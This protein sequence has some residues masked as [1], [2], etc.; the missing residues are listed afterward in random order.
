MITVGSRKKFINK[1]KHWLKAW[2]YTSDSCCSG[3][4]AADQKAPTVCMSKFPQQ[5][6]VFVLS[7]K[8]TTQVQCMAMIGQF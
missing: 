8:G 1:I 3:V 6:D 7:G 2:C 4:G 5:L